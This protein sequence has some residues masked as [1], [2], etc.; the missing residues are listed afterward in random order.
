MFIT[1]GLLRLDTSPGRWCDCAAQPEPHHPTARWQADADVWLCPPTAG[2]ALMGALLLLHSLPG[3]PL[4]WTRN[5]E[6]LRCSD[7][8]DTQHIVFVWSVNECAF[9][10]DR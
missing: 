9:F 3:S 1:S 10:C 4:G 7:K 5:Y 2:S 6:E 8:R